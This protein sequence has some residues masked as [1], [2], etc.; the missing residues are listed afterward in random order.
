MPKVVLD[1]PNE[2]LNT[3][4]TILKNLNPKLISKLEV[5]SK[6]I[7]PVSSSIHHRYEPKKKA[8]TANTTS[9]RYLSPEAFKAKIARKK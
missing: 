3:V 1:V 6:T 2:H 7:E 4:T 5:D 9:G 8:P